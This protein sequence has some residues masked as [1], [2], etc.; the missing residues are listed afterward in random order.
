[1]ARNISRKDD[2]DTVK[3]V[4]QK[5]EQNNPY[6]KPTNPN[7]PDKIDY[8]ADSQLHFFMLPEIDISSDSQVEERIMYYINYCHD[9]NIMP[10]WIGLSLALGVSKNT[11]HNWRSG[12]SKNISSRRLGLLRKIELYFEENLASK[13]AGGKIMPAGPIFLMKN[14]FGYRDQVDLNMSAQGAEQA[15]PDQLQKRLDALPLDD[16]NDVE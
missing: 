8:S 6:Y 13:L 16:G 1:M 7:D 10:N 5:R 12:V 15:S 2:I 4:L 3:R 14:W 9:H 11:L